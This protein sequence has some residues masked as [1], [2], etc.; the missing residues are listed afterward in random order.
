MEYEPWSC[1]E[2]PFS[3]AENAQVLVSFSVLDNM[4]ERPLQSWVYCLA[5]V[6]PSLPPQGSAICSHHSI[7]MPKIQ[8][9]LTSELIWSNIYSAVKK[10]FMSLSD[11]KIIVK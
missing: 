3:K 10:L 9:S 5:T 7:L 1:S 11:N 2:Q 6:G 4:E 8:A